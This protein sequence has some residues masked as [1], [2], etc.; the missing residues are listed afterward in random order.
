MS[1]ELLELVS[2]IDSGKGTTSA[3]PLR[4]ASNAGFSR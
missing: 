2:Q 1:P 4:P 3:V